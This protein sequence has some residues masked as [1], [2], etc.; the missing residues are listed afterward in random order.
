MSN[1][2]LQL[3][4]EDWVSLFSGTQWI[5]LTCLLAIVVIAIDWNNCIPFPYFEWDSCFMCCLVHHNDCIQP[6]LF[7]NVLDDWNKHFFASV[8]YVP[9]RLSSV[10]APYNSYQVW[11]QHTDCIVY[12]WY[13][14]LTL[15]GKC[16]VSN[17]C[18]YY[19]H[20]LFLFHLWPPCVNP[21]ELH[22]CHI[23]KKAIVSLY[24]LHSSW[25]IQTNSH[26]GLL[27]F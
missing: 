23:Q 15:G 13:Y 14:R 6:L 22:S 8:Q 19:N 20:A 1:C 12:V 2:L 26:L 27:P 17:W 4:F 25:G 24:A 7:N 9:S 3:V 16:K 5:P 10:F 21:L 18:I 11:I